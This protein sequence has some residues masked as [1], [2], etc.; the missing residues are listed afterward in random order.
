MAGRVL[1]TGASRGI[2]RAIAVT[3][4]ASGFEIAIN[5]RERSEAAEET[6]A[7]IEKAGGTAV[8]LPFDVGDRAACLEALDGDGATNGRRGRRNL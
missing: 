5:Y 2:G 1:V 8:L 3:L 7:L 4:A 6:R